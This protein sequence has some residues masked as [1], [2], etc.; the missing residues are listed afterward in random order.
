MTLL[1]ENFSKELQRMSELAGLPKNSINESTLTNIP[2]NE[3]EVKDVLKEDDDLLGDIGDLLGDEEE[4][5]RLQGKSE[6]KL[7]KDL[8]TAMVLNNLNQYEAANLELSGEYKPFTAGAKP[9]A[10]KDGTEGTVYSKSSIQKLPG[11]SAEYNRLNNTGLKP[12]EISR[13]MAT[14]MSQEEINAALEADKKIKRSAVSWGQKPNEPQ[15]SKWQ[16]RPKD[17]SIIAYETIEKDGK[18]LFGISKLGKEQLE[19]LQRMLSQRPLPEN[20]DEDIDIESVLLSDWSYKNLVVTNSEHII[21][22][23]FNKAVIR[24]VANSLKRNT[25]NP[26]DTQFVVFI[27]NGINHAIDKTKAKEYNQEL[28]QNYGAWFIQLVKNKVIDQLKGLSNQRLDRK[29]LFDRLANQNTPLVI[30]SKLNPEDAIAG[31]YKVTT[32][33][34]SFKVGENKQPFYRYTFNDPMDA[35]GLFVAKAEGNKK[36]PLAL[37]FLS[38]RNKTEFYKSVPKEKPGTLTN[39]TYQPG[40]GSAEELAR[41]EGIPVVDAVKIAKTEV[42]NILDEIAVEMLNTEVEAGEKVRISPSRIREFLANTKNPELYSNLDIS[43]QK[44]YT[45][46]RKEDYK[47]TFLYIV[48]DDAGKEIGLSKRFAIPSKGTKSTSSALSIGKQYK[49]ALVETLRLML[50]YGDLV[51][52]YSKTVY[53][54]SETG[55]GWETK[56]AY[57]IKNKE[58]GNVVKTANGEIKLPFKSQD[59]QSRYKNVS[60]VPISYVWDSTITG[61]KTK[62]IIDKLSEV[63]LAKNIELPTN[64]FD[65]V[66]KQA[67]Y[68]TAKP[69]ERNDIMKSTVDF[70]NAVRLG[71]RRFFGFTGIDNPIIKKDRAILNDLLKNYQQSQLAES[72]IRSAVRNLISEKVSNLDKKQKWISKKIEFLINKEGLTQKQAAG[73][74]Y[75]MWDYEHKTK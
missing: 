3:N 19:F 44:D 9:E 62:D 24:I 49:D 63:A 26:A 35:A 57:N 53:F 67:K 51:P 5:L 27:E 64:L 41:Y 34:F 23:F 15:T 29:E 4:A 30:D 13:L 1:N 11:G 73:K 72:L 61:E 18:K 56:N 37:E 2:T 21:R 14:G 31:N 55:D 16:P 25:K 32:S 43:G 38:Q 45:V 39:T 69:A 74:A 66:T 28:Y 75:G 22:D 40:E 59:L 46:L 47:N 68:K 48:K 71:L 54:P 70:M 20:G 50:N 8:K 65:P 60:E 17:A 10:E 12:S 42:D 52:K 33:P 7:T 6:G 58:A 36:S